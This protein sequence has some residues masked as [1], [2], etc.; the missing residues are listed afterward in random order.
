M[1]QMGFYNT[2]SAKGKKRQ[3]YEDGAKTQQEVIH[4]FF[5]MQKNKAFT[6]FEVQYIL[7]GDKI[8]ITS[9]RRAMSNLASDGILEKTNI[10]VGEKYG[11]PNHKWRLVK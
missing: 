9:I 7:F 2:I 6:P 1:N 5:T 8:P 11:K 10:L 3:K 4:K